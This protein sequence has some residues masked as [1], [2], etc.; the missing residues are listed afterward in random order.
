VTLV[1]RALKQGLPILGI[2][3]GL[4]LIN[5]ALGGTLYEDLNDQLPGSL[6]HDNFEERPRDYLAHVIQVEPDS[7]LAGVLGCQSTQVN[8]LHHQA[9]ASLHLARAS[10][11]A[12]M[13]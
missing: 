11:F 9:S 4:Q 8:S 1:N 13:G 3:R 12:P 2:C 10:A 6:R 5:V 7:L